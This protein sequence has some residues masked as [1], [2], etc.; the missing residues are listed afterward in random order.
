MTT[1]QTYNELAAETFKRVLDL[2]KVK[3]EEYAGEVD[4]LNNFRRNAAMWGVELEQCW[5]VYAGK[6]WDALAQY[7]RDTAD[8]KER[9]RSEPLESRVD[10]LIVYLL[11]FKCMLRERQP[12]FGGFAMQ[13]AE[14]K[15]EE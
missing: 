9:T 2:S 6:H 10:D 13:R 3:G 7:I 4:R 11:L 15:S 5:G 8:G 12:Q 14:V 1:T